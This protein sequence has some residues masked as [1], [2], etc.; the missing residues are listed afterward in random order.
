[1]KRP[2][3]QERAIRVKLHKAIPEGYQ[4]KVT[5]QLHLSNGTSVTWWSDSFI[6]SREYYINLLIADCKLLKRL[7]KKYT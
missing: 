6:Y 2:I 7:V 5:P 4:H 1:M 3:Y